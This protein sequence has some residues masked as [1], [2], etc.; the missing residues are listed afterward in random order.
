MDVIKIVSVHTLLHENIRIYGDFFPF[1]YKIFLLPRVVS[2]FVF[3]TIFKKKIFMSGTV[4]CNDL[5]YEN[6]AKWFSTAWP[7]CSGSNALHM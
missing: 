7:S 5:T 6:V 4:P 3:K 2:D 1:Q